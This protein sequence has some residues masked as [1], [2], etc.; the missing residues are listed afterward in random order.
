[1]GRHAVARPDRGGMKVGRR[2][3]ALGAEVGTTIR[4]TGF[5]ALRTPLLPFEVLESLGADLQGVRADVETG[6]ADRLAA[7]SA[8]LSERLRA[9]VRDP[10]IREALFCA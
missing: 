5:F 10:S 4:P 3:A 1:M 2:P 6:L 7:D 9:H 8:R